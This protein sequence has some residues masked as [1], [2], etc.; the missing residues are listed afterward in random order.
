[1]PV[2]G[3]ALETSDK[4]CM[5][6]GGA[7]LDQV[8]P[9]C[10]K[11]RDTHPVPTPDLCTEVRTRLGRP[12]DLPHGLWLCDRGPVTQPLC[13]HGAIYNRVHMC[14]YSRN[15][16]RWGTPDPVKLKCQPPGGASLLPAPTAQLELGLGEGQAKASGHGPRPSAGYSPSLPTDSAGQERKEKAR[17]LQLTIGE[18]GVPRTT[19]PGACR[20]QSCSGP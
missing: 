11:K 7:S 5:G 14:T 13:G 16:P 15:H 8:T 17:E 1:M 9:L 18:P 12:G 20:A 3:T 6:Q 19:G 4:R 10:P 2:G